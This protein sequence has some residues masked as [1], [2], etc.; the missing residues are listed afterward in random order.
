MNYKTGLPEPFANK[1]KNFLKKKVKNQKVGLSF[2]AEKKDR[3]GR[4][5]A[6][7][8]LNDDLNLQQALLAKGLAVNIAIPPNLSQQDCYLKTEK[9]AKVAKTGIWKQHK[10]NIL[11]SKN[12]SKTQTGFKF[13]KGRVLEINQSKKAFWL[14]L[15][16]KM[17]L[18]INKSHLS[19]FKHITIE[20]LAGKRIIARGWINYYKKRFNM[21]IKHPDAI[22][23]L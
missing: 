13:V 1:A 14:K 22:E 7:I 9:H 3:Y 21:N 18:R 4:L 8:Y 12:M 6:H 15:S 10:A 5:L 19:Y 23:I 20:S 11:D 17:S 16:N 2:G